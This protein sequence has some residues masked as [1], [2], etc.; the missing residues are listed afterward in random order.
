MDVKIKSCG[1]RSI[2]PKA[3][4]R[5]WEE[6]EEEEEKKVGKEEYIPQNTCEI[7]FSVTF[8]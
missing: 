7:F 8:K 6:E 3:E 2:V 4:I 1:W 5:W